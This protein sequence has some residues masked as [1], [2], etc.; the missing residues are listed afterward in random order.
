MKLVNECFSYSHPLKYELLLNYQNSSI[1]GCI[2]KSIFNL[3][4]NLSSGS[5][6]AMGSTGPDVSPG[7]PGGPG[8]P[9]SP[10]GPCPPDCPAA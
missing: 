9:A 1:R 3:P 10:G 5:T 7:G 8:G 2:I 4:G 6:G